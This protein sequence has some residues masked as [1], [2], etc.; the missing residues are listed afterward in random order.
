MKTIYQLAL[1]AMNVEIERYI[2]L[3]ECTNGLENLRVD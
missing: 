3:L 2:N 1:D